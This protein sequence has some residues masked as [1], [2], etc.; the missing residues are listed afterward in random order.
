MECRRGAALTRTA[1]GRPTQLSPPCAP[2]PEVGWGDAPAAKP[3]SRPDRRPR[4][5]Q[6]AAVAAG[7]NQTHPRGPE[8]QPQLEGVGREVAGLKPDTAL[9]ALLLRTLALGF[10]V[11]PR[12]GATPLLTCPGP[13]RVGWLVGWVKVALSR[14]G[15]GEDCQ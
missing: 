13:G 11:R 8:A 1:V 6:A 4:S 10:P 3:D 12:A 5:T 9:R 7:Q 14:P 15:E 2:R